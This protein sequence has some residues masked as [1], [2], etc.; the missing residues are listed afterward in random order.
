MAHMMELVDNDIKTVIIITFHNKKVKGSL[1][2]E[3]SRDM[4]DPAWTSRDEK[5]NVW[6][7]KYTKW[8]LK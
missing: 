8:H 4:E 6:D 2:M 3:V 1:N 7:E 5:Y